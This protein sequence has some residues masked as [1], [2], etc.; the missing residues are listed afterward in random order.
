M[1]WQHCK[2][3]ASDTGLRLLY[4]DECHLH[5]H[6][7]LAKVWQRPGQR[8]HI[9]AAGVDKRASILGAVDYRSGHLVHL[10]ASTGNTTTLLRLLEQC[11]TVFP[12]D[13]IVLVLDNASYHKSPP[14]RQWFVEHAD[15]IVPLWLP[16]YS[17]RL[18]LIERLWRYLKARIACHPYWNDLPALIHLANQM[19][20]RI[21]ACFAADTYPHMY[22]QGQYFR[23]CA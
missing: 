10:I 8:H 14:V 12:D 18:N 4:A 6:P 11:V 7:S 3:G 15:H 5:T 19:L 22:V 16:T 13:H 23:L 9:K 1:C 17:P 21:R 2:K 20:R